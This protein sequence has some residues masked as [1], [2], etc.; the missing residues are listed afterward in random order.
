[1]MTRIILMPKWVMVLD[2]GSTYSGLDGCAI[3]AVPDEMPDDEVEH[4]LKSSDGWYCFDDKPPLDS[5]NGQ[6]MK[7][8][9]AED[10]EYWRENW[11]RLESWGKGL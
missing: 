4:F 8:L 2:D 1:M 3:V 6:T 7:E 9:E 10:L 11:R 5:N